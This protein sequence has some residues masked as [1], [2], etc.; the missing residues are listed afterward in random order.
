M[1]VNHIDG[2]KTNNH[3]WNLEWATHRENMVHNFKALGYNYTGKLG[4]AGRM[5]Q[6]T[7]TG[8]L[9]PSGTEVARKYGGTQGGVW[10]ALER[11]SGA[12]RGKRYKYIYKGE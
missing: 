4:R 3:I 6:C 8:E 9:F 12:Y 2:D 1:E 5:I 10:Y 7:D 11:G